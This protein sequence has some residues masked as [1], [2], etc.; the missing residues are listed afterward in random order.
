MV[1]REKLYVHNGQYQ[2]KHNTTNL[3]S[4]GNTTSEAEEN[5]ACPFMCW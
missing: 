5:L 1:E 3:D 2:Q 4:Y